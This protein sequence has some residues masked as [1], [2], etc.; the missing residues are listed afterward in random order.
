[1]VHS[2]IGNVSVKAVFS[3]CGK[4]RYTLT[5]SKHGLKNGKRVCVI[6][7]NPSMANDKVADKSVQFVEK[8]IFEKE[9]PEFKRVSELVIVNLYAFLQTKDFEG[10]KDQI[11]RMN[12]SYIGKS[13][14][15]SDIILIAWGKSKKFAERGEQVKEMIGKYKG[16][17]VYYTKKHPSR[18]YYRDFVDKI[19]SS[20]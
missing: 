8:L 9:L 15:E 20:L 6:M 2:H 1:M 7:L 12:D 18:G 11:G 5:V 10:R 14:A 16:K 17:K 19:G 3:S 13:I 4:Y